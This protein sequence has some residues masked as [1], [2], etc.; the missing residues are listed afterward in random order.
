VIR[1]STN[2][3]NKL[4]LSPDGLRLAYVETNALSITATGDGATKTVWELAS[5]KASVLDWL[6]DNRRVLVTVT[7][8]KGTQQLRLVDT[9]T[10]S[11]RPFGSPLGSN[12][13]I[14]HLSVHPDGK[15]IAFSRGSV[16][17]E[18]WMM[19]NILPEEKHA[20]K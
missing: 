12:D 17:E 3:F 9:E 5:G 2:R 10:K 15:H 11:D 8:E 16:I 7:D 20:A 19:K 4:L 13:N 18:V 14:Q 1:R 6:P